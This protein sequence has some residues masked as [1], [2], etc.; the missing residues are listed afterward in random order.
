M[1]TL[2]SPNLLERY[3]SSVTICTT[4]GHDY[5]IRAVFLAFVHINVKET[6]RN[7]LFTS[8]NFG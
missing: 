2:P 3:A 4:E 6:K 5:Q 1:K 7:V 8:N